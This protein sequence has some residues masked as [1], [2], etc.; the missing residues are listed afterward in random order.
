M[1]NIYGK[2]YDLNSFIDKHPGGKFILE[3][4][5]GLEDITALFENYHAFSD[6]EKIQETLKKYEIKEHN[7]QVVEYKT[8]FT[9]YRKLTKKIQEVFP[10]R[11]SIKANSQFIANNSVIMFIGMFCF[12]VSYIS[13]YNFLYKCIAQIVYSTCEMSFGFNYL[14]D[15]SHYGISEYPA[16][17]VFCSKITNAFI[18]WNFNLWFYHHVYYHHS[19]TGLELDIDDTLYKNSN[20]VSQYVGKSNFILFLYIIIPGQH[21]VQGL[22]Y[23]LTPYTSLQ[24]FG[25]IYSN[26]NNTN[27][28]FYDIFDLSLML[29][30]V[31]LLYSVGII[32]T[33][34]HLFIINLL[35]FINVYPNHSSYE[36][37]IEN[38]YTGDDWTKMQI[39]NSGNFLMN[40]LWWTHFFGGINYQIEHHL[41]PN[42]SNIHYPEVSKIVQE[43]CKENNIPYVNKETLYESYKSFIEYVE[44]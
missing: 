24:N 17:N 8:D 19:Y 29:L 10:N 2:K 16:V 7:Q 15:G 41:F 14:H 25:R 40:N 30:K 43:Y 4:T 9:N 31:Y 39:C 35:Y 13:N 28:P 11:E 12:Y 6:I 36:T 26:K 34:I 33:C 37:K 38:R 32:Q 22:L 20:V 3:K 5:K 42:M 23:F 27:K 21:I 1:W 18:L 44:Y